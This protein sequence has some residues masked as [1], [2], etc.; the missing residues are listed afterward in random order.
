[1]INRNR[2]TREIQKNEFQNGEK[3]KIL[4]LGEIKGRDGR[5]WELTKDDA[6][7]IVNQI[8]SDGVD[9]VLDF[10]HR[11]YDYPSD[12]TAAGWFK[13]D[14]FEVRDDGIY[15]SLELTEKGLQAVNNKE[16]RYLSPVFY[17]SGTR[18]VQLESVGL[19]NLPNIPDIPA[20][21]K[22]TKN[23]KEDTMDMIEKL[24]KEKTELEVQLN[25][26]KGKLQKYEEMEKELNK[27]KKERDD[28]LQELNKIKGEFE[29]LKK[30]QYEREINQMVE[31]A[32]KDGKLAPAQKEIA[33]KIG[34]NSK[35]MLEEMI[36]NSPYDFRKLTTETQKNESGGTKLS[37]AT[38]QVCKMLDL[39]PEEVEKNIA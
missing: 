18:I 5:Y 16:Y 6:V 20:L 1:M 28:T 19:T 3:V 30:E 31:N 2:I 34:L 33:L 22:K 17:S 15:A 35:E 14:S 21:N 9:I 10:E 25:E 11:S 24:T 12:E 37:D 13:A 4:P 29:A 26:L 39:S 32:I 23:F 7:A 36:K 8:K 27:I 38:L